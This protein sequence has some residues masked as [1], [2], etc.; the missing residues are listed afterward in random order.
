[1]CTRLSVSFQMSFLQ[2]YQ[3][4]SGSFSKFIPNEFK[5]K[6]NSTD[7]EIMCYIKV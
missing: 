5:A 6:D 1:M 3:E 4:N 7:K 2:S